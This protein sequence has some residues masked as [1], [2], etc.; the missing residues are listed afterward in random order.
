MKFCSLHLDG[1]SKCTHTW[2]SGHSEIR[3]EEDK[4]TTKDEDEEHT[5]KKTQ[6][7]GNGV[8][9]FGRSLGNIACKR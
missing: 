2:S 3:D 9:P 6:K 5:L 1:S 4:D 8:N 7:V